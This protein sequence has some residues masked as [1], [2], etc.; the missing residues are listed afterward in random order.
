MESSFHTMI[1]KVNKYIYTEWI[2]TCA[3]VWRR[4]VFENYKFYEWFEGYSYLGD[5]DFSYR[6]GKDWKLAI[7]ADA[8]FYHH[9]ASKGRGNGFKFGKREVK[10]RIYF[11][12]KHKELSVF[13]CIFAL[14]VRA[15]ISFILALQFDRPIYNSSRILGNISGFIESF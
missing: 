1:G 6:I 11:V 15:F 10:N 13:L 2:S 14:I 9:H 8:N 4:E 5:L 7:V 3:S 12:R